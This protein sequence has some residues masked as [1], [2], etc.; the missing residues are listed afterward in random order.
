[1]KLGS[2]YSGPRVERVWGV[3]IWERLTIWDRPIAKTRERMMACWI[4]LMAIIKLI[5]QNERGD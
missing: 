2:L 1:M 4:L 5:D 3:K